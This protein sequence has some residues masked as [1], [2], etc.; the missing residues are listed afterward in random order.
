VAAEVDRD[1]SLPGQTLG[2]PSEPEAVGVDAVQADDGSALRVAP[3]VLAE[4][5]SSVSSPLP[6]GR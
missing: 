6:E 3:L 1:D 4:D 5:Q 2:K